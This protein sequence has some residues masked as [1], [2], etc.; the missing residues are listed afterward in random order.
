MVQLSCSLLLELYLP[1]LPTLTYMIT[2]IK[3][4]LELHLNFLIH[5][6][7]MSCKNFLSDPILPY[8]CRIDEATVC[9]VKYI[10]FIS[11]LFVSH[12]VHIF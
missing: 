7:G 12:Y 3:N 6:L 2:V 5:V 11:G 8:R 9:Q 1:S 4:N 10:L